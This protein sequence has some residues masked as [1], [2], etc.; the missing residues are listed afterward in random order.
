[1]VDLYS[2]GE[3]HTE[4]EGYP[5]PAGELHPTPAVELKP[6]FSMFEVFTPNNGKGDI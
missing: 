5:Y 6:V 3:S 4:G 1:M 2:E